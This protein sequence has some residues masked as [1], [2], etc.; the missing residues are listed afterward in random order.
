MIKTIRVHFQTHRD[1]EKLRKKKEKKV[2]RSVSYEEII[3]D[4]MEN[5]NK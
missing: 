4:L 2:G 3:Q 1:L 5:E